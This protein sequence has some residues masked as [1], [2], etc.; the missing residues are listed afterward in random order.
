MDRQVIA[1]NIKAL[2]TR[3]KLSLRDVAKRAGVTPAVISMVEN[4]K[5]SP[6]LATLHKILVALGTSFGEFFLKDEK[7]CE[8]FYFPG[9]NMKKVANK[10]RKYILMFPP[11][12]DIKIQIVFEEIFPDEKPETETHK[13][14]VAGYILKGGPLKLSISGKGEKLIHQGDAFYIQAGEPHHSVNAGKDKIEMITCYYPF[15]Y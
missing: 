7:I 3:Q 10:K 5:I 9:K 15:R 12:K 11:Q 13:V 8:R 14:D 4:S 1:G 6:T 2:R